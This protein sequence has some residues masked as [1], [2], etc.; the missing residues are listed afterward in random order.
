MLCRAFILKKR[1]RSHAL[2]WLV[3]KYMKFDTKGK[4]HHRQ[5]GLLNAIVLLCYVVVPCP[6]IS[7][8][9]CAALS[10][11]LAPVSRAPCTVPK[12]M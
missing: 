1:S 4:L 12:Y 2:Q 7:R 8:N 9:S 10:A 6:S 11:S 3:M 5:A